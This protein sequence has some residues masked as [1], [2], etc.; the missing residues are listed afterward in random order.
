MHDIGLSARAAGASSSSSPSAAGDDD[1]KS[2]TRK[3]HPAFA[4]AYARL[5]YSHRAAVAL[6][7]L[8]TVAVAAFLVG[9]ARPS[10]DCATPRLCARFLALPDA[11]AAASDF[12]SLG[13]PWCR[14][15]TG[16]TVK[17]TYKDLLNGL[18]EF[19]PIYETRPI[20]NNMYG[21]GFDHSFGLWFMARWLK[22]DLMIESGAFKG[23]STWVLRQAMPNT[24]I[25]SLSPRHPE[26]YIKKGPAYVD[27]NCTYLAGK[28]FVDFGS[29]DWEK[30]L[31]NHGVSD[32][33]KVLVFF[34]DHQSELKRLKQAL[35]AGFRHLIFEDNYDT[36]TGDHY[37]L[38]Q[39]CDQF[40]IRGGGHSCFWDSDEA[41]FRSKRKKLWEKAVEIDDLCGKDDAWWGVRGYMRDN[42]N[43]S[44]KVISYKEHFQNSRLVESVLDLYWELPPVAG[45]SLTHQTR[46]DPARAADP[47]IE[48]GRYGLFRRTGLER[49]DASVFNGY[50]QMAYVEISGSTLNIDDV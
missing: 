42:F 3:A 33:S 4:A 36:G 45:P 47:I 41:R 2:K 10:I 6:F 28:E 14:S 43:H 1:D 24:R 32:P 31:R 37:S 20:K 23:H 15:K 8:L 19:V 13:V 17:W 7:L 27:G 5:H 11:A 25:I 21:M 16:K 44:N 9:R 35:K 49:L 12:G 48:D 18:E 50:T 34:D 39:I 46:Y 40:Y 22:P 26:K 30:L 38:R 29:V